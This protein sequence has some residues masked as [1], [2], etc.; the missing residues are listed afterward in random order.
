[1]QVSFNQEES[2]NTTDSRQRT[3]SYSAEGRPREISPLGSNP[4]SRK[5]PPS[6]NCDPQAPAPKVSV[7]MNG[8][9]P[10]GP[11]NGNG[12]PRVNGPQNG[13]PV[14]G[15]PVAPQ[16]GGP[17]RLRP[18]P[19]GP[20]GKRSPSLDSTAMAN[21]PPGAPPRQRVS[22]TPLSPEEMK[23]LAKQ[24]EAKTA[25]A[26]AARDCFI[27]PQTSVERFLPDG[28]AVR[29]PTFLYLFFCCFIFKSAFFKKAIKTLLHIHS[30]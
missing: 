25:A 27:I 23:L 3:N 1:M 12:P 13:P 17:Q 22:R 8:N 14:T 2:Y 21:R 4:E 29:K 6:A 19:T 26:Q 7:T 30:F 5:S 10:H 28:I 15:G 16:V 20:P 24:E 9:G 18:P 11:P